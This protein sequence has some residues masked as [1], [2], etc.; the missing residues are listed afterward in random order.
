MSDLD[1]NVKAILGILEAVSTGNS[2][3]VKVEDYGLSGG[4]GV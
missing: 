2:L 3:R 1:N 4:F